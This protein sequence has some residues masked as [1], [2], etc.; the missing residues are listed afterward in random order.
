MIRFDCFVAST[1]N[2]GSVLGAIGHVRS[3]LELYIDVLSKSAPTSHEPAMVYLTGLNSEKRYK[4]LIGRRHIYLGHSQS[5]RQN[6][7]G[8]QQSPTIVT[9]LPNLVPDRP[10]PLP[11]RAS[12]TAGSLSKNRS[13]Y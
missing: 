2:L 8:A 13:R 1:F 5:T 4:I 9:P 7:L 11:K 10:A 12:T 6:S 3:I